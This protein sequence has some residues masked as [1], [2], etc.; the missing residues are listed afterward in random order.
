MRPSTLCLLLSTM[1][2]GA[3]LGVTSASAST[4]SPPAMRPTSLRSAQRSR[5]RTSKRR[6]RSLLRC[7]PPISMPM[8]TT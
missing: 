3:A 1:L 2:A 5:P 7:S 8:S 4:T 6:W